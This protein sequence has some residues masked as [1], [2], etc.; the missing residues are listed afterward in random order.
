MGNEQSTVRVIVN[1]IR[2]EPQRKFMIYLF[3]IDMKKYW[4]ILNLIKEISCVMSLVM[5]QLRPSMGICRC[6]YH[7][8][9]TSIEDLVRATATN[10][11]IKYR[12]HVASYCL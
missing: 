2:T 3:H 6:L 11:F 1:E 5:K 8:I 12:Q 4:I 9:N 10:W 7:A